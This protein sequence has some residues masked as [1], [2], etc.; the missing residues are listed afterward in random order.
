MDQKKQLPTYDIVIVPGTTFRFP[1]IS[2]VDET[3]VDTTTLIGDPVALT[4]YTA[5]VFI[6]KSSKSETT[7]YEGSTSDGAIVIVAADGLIEW[8]IPASVTETFEMGW[9]GIYQLRITSP[10]GVEERLI[11]GKVLIWSE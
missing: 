9:E 7:V 4:N 2:Y 5:S 3:S 11:G 6:K 8:T 10:A 1:Q